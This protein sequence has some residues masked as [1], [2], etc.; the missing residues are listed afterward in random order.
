M[1]QNTLKKTVFIAAG[2]LAGAFFSGCSYIT[3]LRT[4]ELRAVQT[5]TDSL[6]AELSATQAQLLKEQR[7]QT[8]LIRLLRADQQVRFSE[9]ERRIGALESNLSENQVQLSQIQEKTQAIKKTWDEKLKADSTSALVKSAETQKLFQIAY[10]DFS[11][12]R[13]DLAFNGFQDLIKQYPASAEADEAAYWSAECYYAAKDND[14]AEVFYLNYIK[15]FPAGKKMCAALYKLG[16]TYENKKKPK[17]R[18]LVWKK[19]V[20]SCPSTPE[21]QTAKEELQSNRHY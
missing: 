4:A 19:L 10:G 20:E 13:Y 5:H 21:A 1:M 15:A 3:V 17:S 12:G 6:K 18:E 2:L 14:K 11:V 7:D 9:V 16:L 8:E